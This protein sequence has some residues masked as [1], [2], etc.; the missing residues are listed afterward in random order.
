VLRQ[1]LVHFGATGILGEKEKR[2]EVITNC[3]PDTYERARRD[4]NPWPTD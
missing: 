3:Q 2:P 1:N 4:S